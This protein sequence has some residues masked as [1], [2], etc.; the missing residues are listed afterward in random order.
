LY[1]RGSRLWFSCGLL[2]AARRAAACRTGAGATAT[3]G[4]PGRAKRPLVTM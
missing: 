3:S 1:R 4:I 2:P